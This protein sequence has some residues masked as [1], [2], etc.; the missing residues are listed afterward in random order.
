MYNTTHKL[1]HS[2]SAS[3]SKV[4]C[5]DI[6]HCVTQPC[7]CCFVRAVGKPLQ[8]FIQV[9]PLAHRC[10]KVTVEAKHTQTSLHLTVSV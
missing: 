6:V 5:S 3:V 2:I 1:T 10:R 8:A 9:K 4:I 7:I